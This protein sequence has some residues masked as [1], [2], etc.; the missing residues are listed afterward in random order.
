MAQIGPQIPEH[1]RPSASSDSDDDYGPAPPPSLQ[2]KP[3]DTPVQRTTTP[4]SDSESDEDIG[5]LPAPVAGSSWR[6]EQDPIAAFKEREERQ[7]QKELDAANVSNK[8]QRADWMLVPR[9]SF[10][11]VDTHAK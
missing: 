3:V 2:R 1:L 11:T 5:P 10:S 6:L 7:R 9:S 8:P 4:D